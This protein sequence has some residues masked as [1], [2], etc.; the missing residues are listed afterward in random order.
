ME[1][2]IQLKWVK[3]DPKNA[4]KEEI[5]KEIERLKL[6]KNLYMN[7]EQAIKIFINSVYGACGSPWF[8][9]FNTDIAEAVTLQ[10]QDLIKY[11][12]KVINRYFL[13]FWHKDKKVH[14]AMGLTKVEKVEKNVVLYCDTDSNYVVFEEVLSKCD[15]KGTPKDFILK[16]YEVF[17][18]DY[19]NKCYDIYA[20][21]Y[22]TQN[23][24]KF[25]LETISDSG[26]WLAKKKYVYNP[27]WKDP[28]IDIENLSNITAKGVE[29]VQSS[30]APFVRKT[31]ENL[32]KY[33]FTKK[34]D[35]NAIEF[36][37]L[38]KK[39]KEEF[40]LKKIEDISH[41]SIIGDY[42]KHVLQDKEKIVLEKGCPIHVRASAIYNHILYNSKYKRKYQPIRSGEKVK[43]YY[44]KTKD[45]DRN[46]FAFISGSY[47]I[48]FAPE[49]DYDTQFSKSIIQPINRFIE[50]IGFSPISSQLVVATQLF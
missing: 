30:S 43:Y 31:L 48:E 5:K 4:T 26:I 18:A 21:K 27:I 19:L 6:M 39:Y 47:P 11:S 25:E 45:D 17:L 35:F 32:M 10:G 37:S 9:F 23:Y 36:I 7:A 41:S 8:A 24:Q 49:I 34:K 46:V 42:E 13:E 15:W 12:E 50:A 40:K 1:E 14:K 22:G 28:G 44:V 3:I 16:F 20:K 33:I 38:L 2:N 29:L